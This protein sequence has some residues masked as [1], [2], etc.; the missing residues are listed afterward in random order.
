MA[1]DELERYNEILNYDYDLP[2]NCVD[3]KNEEIVLKFQGKE[4]KFTIIVG[5]RVTNM[6][7]D[8]N[9]DYYVFPFLPVCILF[10]ETLKDAIYMWELFNDYWF[11]ADDLKWLPFNSDTGYVFYP[12]FDED[13]ESRDYDISSIADPKDQEKARIF[14][15]KVNDFQKET[16]DQFKA[17]LMRI[18]HRRNL[19][20]FS[21]RISEL[22]SLK[23]V[24]NELIKHSEKA[25]DNYQTELK[26]CQDDA[27][28]IIQKQT[29]EDKNYFKAYYAS[30]RQRK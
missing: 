26:K 27:K 9:C 23:E 4:H 10:C 19:D 20:Y 30:K 13:L 28:L 18:V 7:N 17:W 2:I 29:E 14:F 3:F 16:I 12:T 11:T 6:E 24:C 5:D 8:E 21:K 25:L 22:E 15:D 1:T